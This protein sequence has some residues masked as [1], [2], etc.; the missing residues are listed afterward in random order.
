VVISLSLVKVSNCRLVFELLRKDQD[1]LL[2]GFRQEHTDFLEEIPIN[3]QNAEFHRISLYWSLFVSCGG[4]DAFRP[5][6]FDPK[7][8]ARD[9][10]NMIGSLVG[11]TGS[12]GFGDF[13]SQA[14]LN[15]LSNSQVFTLD[16]IHKLDIVNLTNKMT[17]SL[18]IGFPKG[19]LV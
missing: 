12:N 2:R 3:Q 6:K 16:D 8:T 10:T 5:R 15:A 11:I 4:E 9:N 1:Q 17:T 18:P 14:M 7:Y 19:Y 13:D